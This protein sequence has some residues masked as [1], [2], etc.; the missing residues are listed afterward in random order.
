MMMIKAILLISCILLAAESTE[1][2]KRIIGG[3][4]ASKGQFPFQVGIIHKQYTTLS[5]QFCGGSLI[6][7][8]WVSIEL[9]LLN[10]NIDITLN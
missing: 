5:G 3:Q 6:T 9:N 8:R 7:Q 2:H 10:C 4:Q 1:E